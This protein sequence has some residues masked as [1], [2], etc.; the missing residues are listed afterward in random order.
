MTRPVA[1]VLS[2][3]GL[4]A[5]C[6]SFSPDGG[7]SDVAQGV[8]R[9]TGPAIGKNVVKIASAEQVQLAKKQVAGLLA[10]PLSADMAVQVAFLN[11]R[12]LQA[13]YNACDLRGRLRAASLPPNRAC[14]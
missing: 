10:R 3:A 7:M 12:D 4:L 13:A 11:N 14:P 1:I 6:A 9:E 5:G 2:L 8:G